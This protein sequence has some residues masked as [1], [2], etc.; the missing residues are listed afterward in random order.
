MWEFVTKK[1][2]WITIEEEF[3]ELVEESA[4]DLP[5]KIQGEAN[6]FKLIEDNEALCTFLIDYFKTNIAELV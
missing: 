6:L 4:P 5:E 1:G 2:A 3:R